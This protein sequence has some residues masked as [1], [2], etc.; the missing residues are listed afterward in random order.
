MNDV[1]AGKDGAPV[2]RSEVVEGKPAGTYGGEAP[3]AD[4]RQWARIT[5]WVIVAAG[6]AVF[7][8]TN[9]EQVTINF[10][11]FTQQVP[12]FVAL[13]LALVLGILLGGSAMFWWRRRAAKKAERQAARP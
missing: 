13:V 12:L 11:F 10:V 2:P 3:P 1:P 8:L 7:I 9:R 4:W 6:A 5:V